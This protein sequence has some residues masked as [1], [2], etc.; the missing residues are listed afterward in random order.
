VDR[1]RKTAIARTA[2]AS[3]PCT[4]P[5]DPSEP[6]PEYPWEGC[7]QIPP[8]HAYSA[9][10]NALSALGMDA[11]RYGTPS[12]NPLGD[13]VRSG[14]VVL[15]KPNL[16]CEAREG[17]HDQWEQIVTSA[18][19][20][21][22]VLD[23]VLIALGGRG[24]IV[25]ADS[26]Q[27]DSDFD[28][29]V[30]RTG[31]RETVREL[32]RRSGV[33]VELIDLRTERWIVQGGVCSGSEKLPGDPEGVSR[34][35]LGGRSH[36]AGSPGTSPF[37]GASYDSD[38]TN[39][40][41]SEGRHVYEICGTALAADVIINIPKLKTHKK[42]GMTGC[43]KGMVGLAGDKNLLPHYRFGSPSTGGDQY[44]DGRRGGCLE[45][46]VV[47][48]AKRFMLGG[49]PAARAV[50]RMLRPLGYGL[51]GSTREVVR[52]GNWCGNDTIWRMVLDLAA[53]ITYCDRDGTILDRPARRFFN[54]ADGIVGGEGNGPLDADPVSSGM[55]VAGESP[56]VV[57]AVSAAAMGMNPL[58]LRL[59]RG[60]FDSRWNFAP[61]PPE[62]VLTVVEPGGGV[63]GLS[64]VPTVFRFERHFGWRE[65]FGGG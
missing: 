1:A 61:C 58:S 6:V 65:G 16:V 60:G 23:Y 28:L 18:S 4:A 44:P 17:D 10:R 8:N 63:T 36:F 46:A 13:V 33:P 2:E 7:L 57:D 34:I 55:I 22:A 40:N 11:G 45:N 64:S 12:W 62:E 41:H 59:I 48:G 20:V 42:S 51:F 25:V 49:G 9:V 3:Y 35:D 19:V 15:V 24:R 56:L 31:L 5:F 43:L 21:R 47:R 53:I 39:I 37:Y 32:R 26:P 14:D 54:V 38:T 29:T 50:V 52:S 30:E 27:T